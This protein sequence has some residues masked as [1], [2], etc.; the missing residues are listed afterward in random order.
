MFSEEKVTHMAAY[1]LL[2]NDRRMP[3]IKLLK[4]LYLAERQAFDK[5]GSSMSGD[6][7]VS[8]PHG[9]VMSQ[10]YDLMKGFGHKQ[11]TWQSLIQDEADYDVSL[12]PD[13]EIEE[14]DELSRSEMRILDSIIE[15]YG[16]MGP[17]QLVDFTHDSCDE[18]QDPQ[19]SSFPIKPEA[20]FRALGKNDLEVKKLVDKN[21]EEQALDSI[22]ALLR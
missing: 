5:W 12:K 17:F 18:W 16:H 13:T 3:C 19:G 20:I 9:P 7:F 14:L 1:L 15:T 22:R 2:K 11:S 6:R 21:R 8:M 10:T 4:L